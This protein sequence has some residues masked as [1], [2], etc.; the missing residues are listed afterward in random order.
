MCGARRGTAKDE[1][2]KETKAM[3]APCEKTSCKKGIPE[4]PSSARR[5]R[6]EIVACIVRTLVRSTYA[7]RDARKSEGTPDTTTPTLNAYHSQGFER[8]D[9]VRNQVS[10]SS[11]QLITSRWRHR[12]ETFSEPQLSA[13]DQ[14]LQ[15]TLNERSVTEGLHPWHAQFQMRKRSDGT[16]PPS[17]PGP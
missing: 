9:P 16:P 3:L 15:P 8:A 14:K 13:Y 6:S 5:V 10:D 1:G 11:T 17:T 7:S 12:S 2:R 4:G